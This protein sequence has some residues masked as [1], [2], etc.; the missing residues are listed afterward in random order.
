MSVKT[1]LEKCLNALLEFNDKTLAVNSKIIYKFYN[2]N[3]LPELSVSD[4][5]FCTS[6]HVDKPEKF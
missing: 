6:L 1:F 4:V 3:I 2:H 5:V